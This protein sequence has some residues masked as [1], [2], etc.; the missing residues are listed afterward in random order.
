MLGP[1]PTCVHLP[2]MHIMEKALALKPDGLGAPT[3]ALSTLCQRQ[4]S[5]ALQVVAKHQCNTMWYVAQHRA[6]PRESASLLLHWLLNY[7]FTSKDNLSFS[8]QLLPGLK[9]F[10]RKCCFTGTLNFTNGNYIHS[11]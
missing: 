5:H 7:F 11:S 9:L 8:T 2:L 1:G 6:E 3:R 10:Q 4:T